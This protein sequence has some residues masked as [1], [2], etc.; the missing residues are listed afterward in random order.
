M[1]GEGASGGR[2]SCVLQL[3]TIDPGRIGEELLKLL[4][5]AGRQEETL[6]FEQLTLS[7]G[8]EAKC[9]SSLIGSIAR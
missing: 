1:R 6:E 2:S 5:K 3:R 8:G 4:G 7:C 9:N